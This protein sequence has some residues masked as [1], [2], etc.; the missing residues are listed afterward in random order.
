MKKIFVILLVLFVGLL[1]GCASKSVIV[2]DFSTSFEASEEEKVENEEIIWPGYSTNNIFAAPIDYVDDNTCICL[3]EV[4]YFPGYNNFPENI[5]CE[6]PIRKPYLVR[7]VNNSD[8]DQIFWICHHPVFENKPDYTTEFVVPA[9]SIRYVQ[10]QVLEKTTSFSISYKKSS[11]GYYYDLGIF[12][13]Q[14]LD[15]KNCEISARCLNEI[16][17]THCLEVIFYGEDAK[18][19]NLAWLV[20]LPE[21]YDEKDLIDVKW[22]LRK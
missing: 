15:W 10:S 18:E 21:S 22:T 5:T 20:E 13:Y 1:V 4:K 7:I 16:L 11:N 8:K 6:N 3:Y 17:Q 9:N 2:K 12:A 19:K 14:H